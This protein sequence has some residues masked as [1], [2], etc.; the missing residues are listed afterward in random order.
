[1][2]VNEKKIPVKSISQFR[3][4]GIRMLE[5]VNLAMIYLIHCKYL[6]KCHNVPLLS[7]SIK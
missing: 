1:M 7:T 3:R 2:N 6:C 4:E 5:G